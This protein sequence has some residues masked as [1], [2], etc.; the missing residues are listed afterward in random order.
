VWRRMKEARYGE[1]HG[2][3]ER[4]KERRER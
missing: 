4:K 1:K 3:D 2:M